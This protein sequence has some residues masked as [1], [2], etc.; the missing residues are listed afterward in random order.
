MNDCPKISRRGFTKLCMAAASLIAHRAHSR[1]ASDG[2]EAVHHYE[3]ARLVDPSRQPITVDDLRTGVNYIFH[4]P[5]FTTPCFL[6]NL[7]ER[8]TASQ[9]LQTEDGRSYRWNGG[10][11][12]QRAVVAFSAICAHLMTHPA[13]EVSFINYRHRAVNFRDKAKEPARESRV[14]YCCSEKS[15]YAAA[16]ARVLGGPAPQPLAV[17]TLDYESADDAF[18]ATGTQGGEM[19]DRFFHE[20]SFR[21]ALAYGTDD[22]RKPVGD[23]ATVLPLSE[24][25][26]HQVLC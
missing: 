3:R 12:P 6:I 19:F 8:T 18:F 11:G 17:I 24:F 23:T 15:V 21:L 16:G 1:S 13:P 10:V 9:N 20:H 2:L 25:C 26:K 4:Y 14:I 5:Y 7:G 22:V